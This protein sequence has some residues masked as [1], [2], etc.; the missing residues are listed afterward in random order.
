MNSEVLKEV[1]VKYPELFQDLKIHTGR[2]LRQAQRVY[3]EPDFDRGKLDK[4]VKLCLDIYIDWCAVESKWKILKAHK[5]ADYWHAT[6]HQPE[7]VHDFWVRQIYLFFK[8]NTVWRKDEKRIEGSLSIAKFCLENLWGVL[9]EV[10][11]ETKKEYF[12]IFK[13]DPSKFNE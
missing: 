7:S 13:K 1:C 4:L 5:G 10:N 2:A 3:K 11:Q 9:V 8:E 6:W 12:S